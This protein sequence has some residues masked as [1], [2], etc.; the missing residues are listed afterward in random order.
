MDRYNVSEGDIRVM[1][2]IDKTLQAF[3]GLSENDFSYRKV[4]GVERDFEILNCIK[5][6]EKDV[7]VV[8]TPERAEV[9]ENGWMENL[10]EFRETLDVDKLKPKY[11]HSDFPIRFKGELIKS[12]NPR[13][14]VQLDLLIKRCI[15]ELYASGCD[16]IYEFGCGTGYNLVELSEMYPEKNLYGLDFTRSGVDILGLLHKKLKKNI[17]GSRFDFTMPDTSY[18]IERGGVIFTFAALEQIGEKFDKFVDYLQESDA[19][20]VV[21]LEPIVEL[22]DENSL[23][24]YLAK[25]F[26]QKRG[27]LSGLLPYLKKLDGEGSIVIEKVQRLHL[28]NHNHE[29]YTLIVWSPRRK[30]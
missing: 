6:I 8:G 24:D 13:F 1:L 20:L 7:Q 10:E 30:K 11:F 25:R 29:G 18:Q 22:Y 5:R 19:K 3:G 17:R 27:Y 23:F 15:F 14:Q 28:G 16:H 4:F 2:G 9:W 21:H 26:H 12:E